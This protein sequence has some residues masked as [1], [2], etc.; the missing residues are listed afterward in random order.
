MA[1][2]VLINRRVRDYRHL[3]GWSQ[4]ELAQRAGVSRTAVS[5]I[6]GN[7]L[8]PSVA[9]ALALAAT[10]GCS[11]EALFGPANGPQQGPEWAWPPAQSPCRYWVAQIGNRTLC[12]PAEALVGG[13]APHD[14][15]WR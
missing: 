8:V 2:P 10:L 15:V 9:A 14:A 13:L 4:A 11:V 12:Y 6:E 1:P 5:A 7:R 3:R